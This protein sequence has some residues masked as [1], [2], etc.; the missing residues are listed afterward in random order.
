M[1]AVSCMH[2][3]SYFEFQGYRY[4]QRRRKIF[5]RGSAPEAAAQG[6]GT[7]EGLPLVFCMFLRFDCLVDCCMLDLV[8][9]V[10]QLDLVGMKLLDL[11]L[12]KM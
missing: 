6:V 12:I 10:I 8:K 1:L 3:P 5:Y 7:G 4:R 9:V 11:D 2:S